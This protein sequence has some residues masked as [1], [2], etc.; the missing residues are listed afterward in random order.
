MKT[1]ERMYAGAGATPRVSRVTR[2]I[3]SRAT[4]LPL[5]AAVNSDNGQPTGTKRKK[6]EKERKKMSSVFSTSTATGT[7]PSLPASPDPQQHPHHHAA[8]TALSSSSG[9]TVG[10]GLGL[11]SSTGA[12]PE[13]TEHGAAV[14]NA[15][16][17]YK[18][19]DT[20]KG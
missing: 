12:R 7:P 1:G 19:R 17:R 18:A 20:S 15:L 11:S 4:E 8:R 5:V 14:L 9:A 6:R 16:E 10:V 2:A 3:S 13:E